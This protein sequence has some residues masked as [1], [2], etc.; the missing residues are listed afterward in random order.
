MDKKL[1]AI[2]IDDENLARQIVKK[3]LQ[4]HTDIELLA[5]CSNGFDGIKKII[6]MHPDLIFL[7]IQMPKI[8]GFEMLELLEEPPVIIFTTAYDQYAIKAFEVNAADYLLKPFSR[9]R[10]DEAIVKA[11]IFLRDKSAQIDQIKKLISHNDEQN[12]FLERIIVKEGS[13]INIIPIEEIKYIEAQDDYVMIY[14]GIGKFLKQKTMK[15]LEKHLNPNDFVRIHRSY[16][17]ALKEIEKLEQITKES[18]I[19]K[20]KNITRPLPVS[21]SGYENLRKI[22]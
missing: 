5:D 14:S 7:D 4:D 19:V 16:I 22:L 20:L 12:E 9:E 13:K 18:F 15:F 3:Y 17:T 1:T 11:E 6:E 21:R 8:N 2:V 10:F